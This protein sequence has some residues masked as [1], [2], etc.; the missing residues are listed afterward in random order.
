MYL[1]HICYECLHSDDC[2]HQY[3]CDSF[4]CDCEHCFLDPDCYEYD[5]RT[6]DPDDLDLP[7]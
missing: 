4:D 3:H 1:C 6:F 7:F 2:D 5:D